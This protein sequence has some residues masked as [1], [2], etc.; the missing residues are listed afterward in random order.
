MYIL[1]NS[2]SNGNYNAQGEKFFKA[3]LYQHELKSFNKEATFYR[4]PNKPSCIVIILTNSRH[5]L[6]DTILLLSQISPIFSKT[7]PKEM[8]QRDFKNFNQEIFGQEF[9]QVHDYTS[10]EENFLGVLNKHASLKKK[11]L[12]AN[13]VSYVLGHQGKQL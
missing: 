9:A 4:N 12:H 13:H 8:M 11:V 7:G 2:I 5:T 3:F 1:L 6:F 10:F